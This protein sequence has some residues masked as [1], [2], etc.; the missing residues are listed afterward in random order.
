[1]PNN[2]SIGM[3][4]TDPH[5]FVDLN[6]PALKKKRSRRRRKP[7]SAKTKYEA[8]EKGGLKKH[9]DAPMTKRDLYFVLNCELVS[10][11]HDS[12]AVA[13][14][15][16]INWDGEVVLDTFVQVP[17]PV[18]DFRDTGISPELISSSNRHAMSFAK[19]RLTVHQILKGKILIGYNL[20][21]HLTALGLSHPHS[22][23]RDAVRFKMFQYEEIDGVTGQRIVVRRSL[24]DLS[25]EFLNREHD[26]E[27]EVFLSPIES[28][29]VSL[30]LYKRFR[31][32]WESYLVHEAHQ[33]AINQTYPTPLSTPFG[34]EVDYENGTVNSR[35]RINSYDLPPP[36]PLSASMASPR[37]VSSA[38]ERTAFALS[39]DIPAF[40]ALTTGLT[41]DALELF[42][43]ESQSSG[44]PFS[45]DGSLGGFES[46]SNYG[47]SA[48]YDDSIFSDS[49]A[50]ES[51]A[52][53]LHDDIIL[54][55]EK[56]SSSWFRFGSRKSKYAQQTSREP[57][58]SL[59][60]EPDPTCAVNTPP[61]TRE[62]YEVPSTNGID[63]PVEEG[64]KSSS[65]FSFRKPKS[66]RPGR[67][68]D[69]DDER[70]QT[71]VK[72]SRAFG[73]RGSMGSTG[74]KE[75]VGRASR[76]GSMGSADSRK[77]P[78]A[79]ETE[80]PETM[81]TKRPGSWFNFRR[82]S[83]ISKKGSSEKLERADS[84][85]Q[86][87]VETEHTI[88]VEEDWMREVVGSPSSRKNDVLDTAW[89][90]EQGLEYEGTTTPEPPQTKKESKWLSRFMRH[91]RSTSTGEKGES[92]GTDSLKGQW[93]EDAGGASKQDVLNPSFFTSIGLESGD[94][95]GNF[96]AR[97]RLD[98]EATIPAVASEEDEGS[99]EDLDSSGYLLQNMQQEFPYL[100]I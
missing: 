59:F 7:R 63:L 4:E 21:E 83:K 87:S 64:G 28:C 11:G 55:E 43:R 27:N 81:E 19:V 85:E 40:P 61:A 3:K 70:D 23:I 8:S 68:E 30:D 90:E 96:A 48:Y 42:T 89:L 26:Y 91:S 25:C 50:T 35:I 2:N 65:W 67:R 33:K 77:E 32:Q 100:T 46:S 73:R 92:S 16:M 14:V 66:P 18:T 76:R 84:D 34:S 72:S 75:S 45:H 86:P 15:T 69:S 80:M 56:S 51:I 88:D 6:P 71:P 20:Q 78:A 31:Q 79:D 38:H 13:R 44:K 52:S 99:S 1:M 17:V 53:S 36:S 98:T 9:H 22:D 29:T 62:T 60:E 74:K 47:S 5:A 57:L 94:D 54:T 10:I 12:S 41:S 37:M 93:N 95:Q 97:G 24:L 82:S 49:Y 58:S 39:D